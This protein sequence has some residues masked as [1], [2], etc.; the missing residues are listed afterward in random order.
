MLDRAEN[1][2]STNQAVLPLLPP[3]LLPKSLPHLL[4]SMRLWSS[5]ETTV[6]SHQK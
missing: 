5:V 2:V 6:R 4:R 1:R 3:R